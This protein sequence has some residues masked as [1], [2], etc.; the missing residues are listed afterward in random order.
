MKNDDSPVLIE[1]P[2]V[3]EKHT[4]FTNQTKRMQE[5]EAKK[6]QAATATMAHRQQTPA[7][8]VAAEEQK[9]LEVAAKEAQK[10]HLGLGVPGDTPSGGQHMNLHTPLFASR[11]LPQSPPGGAKMALPFGV[12]VLKKESNE[13]NPVLSNEVL[14]AR[15]QPFGSDGFDKSVKLEAPFQRRS[16]TKLDNP[17][18]SL[19]E[20]PFSEELRTTFQQVTQPDESVSQELRI[21]S[22]PSAPAAAASRVPLAETEPEIVQHEEKKAEEE[23][24]PKRFEEEKA[25]IFSPAQHHAPS[26]P[27][28]GTIPSLRKVPEQKPP[29]APA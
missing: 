3:Y 26:A 17:V 16:H 19:M 15:P 12:E 1:T 23:L 13:V 8:V 28:L 25:D 6:R 21:K 9:R 2:V 29:S 10:V 20:D 11:D 18:V 4:T 5:E 14:L 22:P 7:Q 27:A 24:P